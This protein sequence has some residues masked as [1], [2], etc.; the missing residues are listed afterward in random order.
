MTKLKIDLELLVQSFSFNED[1]LGKEYLDTHTGEIINIPSEIDKVVEGNGDEEELDDW[2]KELLK[3]AYAITENKEDNYVLIP[4]IEESYFY[5]VMAGFSKEKVSSEELSGE[6]IN[7]LNSSQPM[8][9]F[10]NIIF[11]NPEI[12]EDWEEYEDQKL[13]EY[14]INWLKSIGI[15]TE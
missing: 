15:E 3:D 14:A 9:G 1:D 4:N 8:R 2:Q 6:L 12:L 11:E 13:K 7:A 10:K 5:D